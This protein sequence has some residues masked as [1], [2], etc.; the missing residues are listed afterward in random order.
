MP[1]TRNSVST[2]KERMPSKTGSTGFPG[3]EDAWVVGVASDAYPTVAARPAFTVL[4]NGKIS[5]FCGEIRPWKE[6]LRR[7]LQEKGY[8]AV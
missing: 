4:D 6:A 3:W 7:Y 2:P 1:L 8:L 5:Q